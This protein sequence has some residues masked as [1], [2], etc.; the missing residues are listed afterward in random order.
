MLVDLAGR[1]LGLLVALQILRDLFLDMSLAFVVAHDGAGDRGE[2]DAL[3]QGCW[4]GG[5]EFA[6]IPR[7]R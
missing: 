2:V 6:V 4:F 1:R 5:S 3:K 7:L